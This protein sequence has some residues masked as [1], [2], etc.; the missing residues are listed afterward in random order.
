MISMNAS[1]SVPNLPSPA[2]YNFSAAVWAS[3]SSTWFPSSRTP[4][5][6]SLITFLKSPET[7]PRISAII[8]GSS[9]LT[10]VIPSLL[11]VNKTSIIAF[12]LVPAP[13]VAD[14]NKSKET[15]MAFF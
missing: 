14:L 9:C 8:L 15:A 11:R 2:L 4:F 6:S 7:S 1:S 13:L 3:A 5:K 10:L 12:S